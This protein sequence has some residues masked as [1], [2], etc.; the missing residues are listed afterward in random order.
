MFLNVTISNSFLSFAAA[1]V[2][3]SLNGTYI[4]II[5]VISIVHVVVLCYDL[6]AFKTLV[7]V[8]CCYRSQHLTN[9]TACLQN[10]H[11]RMGSEACNKVLCTLSSEE[12]F[13]PF[14]FYLSTVFKLWLH[15]RQTRARPF[16]RLSLYF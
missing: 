5:L 12:P 3:Q 2:I 8:C 11:T 7:P 4:P 6:R 15:Q 10:R 13:Q 16:N 1:M 14:K 9:C